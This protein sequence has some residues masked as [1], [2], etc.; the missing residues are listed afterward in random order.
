MASESEAKTFDRETLLDL[1][2]NAI[3]LGMI[4][5]FVVVFVLINPFGSSPV[6]TAIQLSLL[7][8]P[9]A[10]LA[11]LTYVSGKAVSEAEEELEER[12]LEL[13]EETGANEEASPETPADE[14]H[15][16]SHA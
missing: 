13:S 16:E 14:A 1:V 10:A 15:D 7:I 3:P 12:G 4:L 9:F 5:F 11:F 8:V 6:N 2:V